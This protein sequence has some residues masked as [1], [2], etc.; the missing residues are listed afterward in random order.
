V[1]IE[2][3]EAQAAARARLFRSAA[4]FNWPQAASMSRPRGVLTGAE[5]PASN[6][7]LLNALMRSSLEHS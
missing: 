7:M 4:V 2:I 1:L 6:T 5:M 3:D